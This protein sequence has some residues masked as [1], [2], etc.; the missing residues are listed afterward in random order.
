MGEDAGMDEDE[1]EEE[2]EENEEEE[3]PP[4]MSTR[5]EADPPSSY[6]GT[7]DSIPPE[8]DRPPP[9]PRHLLATPR[10]PSRLQSEGQK[11]PRAQN[12]DREPEI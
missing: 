12:P 4:A 5:L 3:V 11:R 6:P 9:I 10:P 8:P 1:E 7:P 2:E